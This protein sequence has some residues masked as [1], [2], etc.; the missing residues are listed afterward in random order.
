MAK[1]WEF[2]TRSGQPVIP[3]ANSE[4]GSSFAWAPPG[5]GDPYAWQA[6]WYALAYVQHKR[7]AYDTLLLFSLRSPRG[8]WDVAGWRDGR[9][10]RNAPVYD[11]VEAAFRPRPFANGG[12]EATVE[13]DR[14]WV[15]IY[16]LDAVDP[17]GL[18]RVDF[19]SGDAH[20]GRHAL[21]MSAPTRVRQVADGLTP[22]RPVTLSARVK[23]EGA[24]ARLAALGFDALDGTAE[25]VA[26]FRRYWRCLAL[27][28]PAGDAN[29]ELGRRVVGSG[30]CR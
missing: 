6:R 28:H 12:F 19:A 4:G 21:R 27:H 29:A 18:D 9:F 20:G 2:M 15:A 22:G 11:A 5:I 17:P 30:W 14:R 3:V 16:D 23:V 26:E 13:P 10:I 25:I 1:P 7:F 24:A 8:L